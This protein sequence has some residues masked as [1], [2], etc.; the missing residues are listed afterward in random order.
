MIHV[1]I[2]KS[3]IDPF[4]KVHEISREERVRLL[5]T[6]K[7]LAMTITSLRGFQEA[8]ITSGG[9]HVKEINP[10]TMESKIVKNLYIAGEM[11]DV[12]ALTGGYNLQIAWSTGYLAG[13]A[14]TESV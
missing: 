1:I 8:I 12:D 9:I 14:A 7:G 13:M 3:Q 6:I 5:N 10:A 2:E 11:I 4:K